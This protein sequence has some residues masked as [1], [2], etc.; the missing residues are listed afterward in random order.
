MNLR[1]PTP[2]LLTREEEGLCD[3]FFV[4][5]GLGSLSGGLEGKKKKKKPT[6]ASAVAAAVASKPEGV[7]GGKSPLATRLAEKAE[8][9]PMWG[10]AALLGGGVLLLAGSIW[11]LRRRKK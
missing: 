4:S 8:K 11:W 3:A 6:P 5:G 2:Y 7:E 9:V 10:W 1:I